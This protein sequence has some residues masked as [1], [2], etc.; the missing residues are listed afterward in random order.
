MA[1]ISQIEECIQTEPL[2]RCGANLTDSAVSSEESLKLPPTKGSLT[3][4][5]AA[6]LVTLSKRRGGG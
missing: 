4:G 3:G 1:R 6:K 2:R 5:K